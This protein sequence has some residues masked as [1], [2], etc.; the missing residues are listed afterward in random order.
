MRDYEKQ[1]LVANIKEMIGFF[2]LI[3]LIIGIMY[4]LAI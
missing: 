1:G 2:I 3:T 4:L